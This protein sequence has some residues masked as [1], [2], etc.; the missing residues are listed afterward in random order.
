VRSLLNPV[1][2][3]RYACTRCNHRQLIR[4]NPLWLYKLNEV[5]FQG[6]AENI[7]VPLLS[8]LHFKR[9]SQRCFSYV[10]DSNVEWT[11]GTEQISGNLDL[12][13]ACDGKYYVGEAECN[14]SISPDQLDFYRRVALNVPVDGMVFSTTMERWSAATEERIKQLGQ[15]FH[16]E[17]VVIT[18]QQ[19]YAHGR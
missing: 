2:N 9:K 1:L 11:E 14:D 12:V 6:F 8:L 7:Q 15:V 5:V 18:G 17:V 16:G 19:L 13:F 10:S 4:T 3:R